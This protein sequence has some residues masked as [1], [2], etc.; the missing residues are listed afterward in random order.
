MTKNFP[1][2]MKAQIRLVNS[3]LQNHLPVTLYPKILSTIQKAQ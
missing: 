1:S 3:H 2:E